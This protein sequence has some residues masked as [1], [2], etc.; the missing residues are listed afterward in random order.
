MWGL[1]YEAD[2]FTPKG[3]EENTQNVDALAM[4]YDLFKHSMNSLGFDYQGE[5]LVASMVTWTPK[6]DWHATSVTRRKKKSMAFVE[7]L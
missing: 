4:C 5:R 7:D 1:P 2:E 3:V 6:R